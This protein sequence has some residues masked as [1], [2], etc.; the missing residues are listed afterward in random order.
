[1]KKRNNVIPK[2]NVGNRKYDLTFIKQVVWS[3]LNGDE[4]Y[5]RTGRR[6]NVSA[7][8][9]QQ[10][11]SR[12]S[13]DLGVPISASEPMTKEQQQELEALKKRQKELENQLELANRKIFGL[14]TLIDVA[15]QTL[16]IDIR[17]KPGP[18]QSKK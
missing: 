18:K 14:Q 7:C 3:Y 8:Q 11:V 4:G 13:S 1:M 2:K 10:W 15:E 16:H 6:F 9:V 17:K 12:F 5:M